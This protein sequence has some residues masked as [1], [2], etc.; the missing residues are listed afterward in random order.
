LLPLE[1][2]TVTPVAAALDFT[3]VLLPVIFVDPPQ[4][5]KTNIPTKLY[6]ESLP[7]LIAPPDLVYCA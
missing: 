1:P 7:R 6:F 5:A 4:P 2:L 3:P